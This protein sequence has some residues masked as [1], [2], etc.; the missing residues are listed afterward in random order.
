MFR[1]VYVFDFEHIHA[2]ILSY[3]KIMS[4]A[5]FQVW[6]SNSHVLNGNSKIPSVSDFN[7]TFRN[8]VL[9]YAKIFPALWSPLIW[10]C[11]VILQCFQYTCK[12]R[13]YT[14]MF[15]LAGNI[16]DWTDLH[17]YA[18]QYCTLE[19]KTAICLGVISMPRSLSR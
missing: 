13:Q 1:N 7:S 16:R 4:S 11:L 2:R 6:I 10:E 14:Y 3:N 8:A 17:R 5:G 19:D 12:V 9:W 15:L 18:I